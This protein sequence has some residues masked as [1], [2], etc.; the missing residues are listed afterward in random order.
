MKKKKLTAAHIWA[1]F[2]ESQ[3]TFD[4]KM[5]ESRKEN[6][7]RKEEIDK[8]LK[9]NSNTIGGMGRSNGAFAENLFFHSLEKS[10]TFAGVHFDT[11]SN[12]FKR[13]KKLPDGTK[14]ED[15]FDIVMT[16]DDAIAI[17]EVK[18][19]AQDDD[20]KK[21]IEKKIPNF[22]ALFS[23]YAGYKIYLGLGSFS[24]DEYT[25]KEA[26]KLGVGLLQVS[27]D[28]VEY[29]TDWVRAY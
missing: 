19:K 6:D 18:Y 21:M 17:I 24:F 3:K 4:Q 14:L 5:E 27:G 7:R 29:K 10:K 26:E 11:V 8:I 20:V 9:E 1:M 25:A 12:K 13:L 28:T 2:A 16:N 15:Q 22:K 23:D